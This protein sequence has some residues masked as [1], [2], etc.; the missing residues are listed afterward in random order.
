MKKAFNTF[1]PPIFLLEEA[2]DA[3]GDLLADFRRFKP[4]SVEDLSIQRLYALFIWSEKQMR[5]PVY[6]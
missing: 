5:T 6:M 3:F 4:H 1:F 2:L